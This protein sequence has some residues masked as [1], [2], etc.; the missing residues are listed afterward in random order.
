VTVVRDPRLLDLLARSSPVA[1]ERVR[2][3]RPLVI[4]CHLG[5]HELPLDLVTSVRVLVRVDTQILDTTARDGTT[6]ILPGGRREAGE[7]LVQTGCREVHE[8]TGWVVDPDSFV[9][10]GFMHLHNLG[11]PNPPYP[12]PDVLWPVFLANGIQVEAEGW[13]DTEGYVVS[14]CLR[15]IVGLE[16][17]AV[18]ELAW[19]YAEVLRRQMEGAP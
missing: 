13:V 12:H 14:S 4:S 18:G 19:C 7:T 15:P 17:A 3:N 10:L 1:I 8:E 2:W 9:P 16:R 5:D 11:E 6:S